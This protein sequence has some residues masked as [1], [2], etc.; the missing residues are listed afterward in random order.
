M[1]HHITRATRHFLLWLL[2]ALAIGSISIRVLLLGVESHKT[3]LESKILE[4]T[5]IPIEIGTLRANMRGF[6]PEIILKD[7]RVLAVDAGDKPAIQLEEVRF[8]INPVQLLFTQHI[9]PS[10]WVSIVGI[11]LSIVRK[12][13]GA[14]SIVGLNQQDSEQPLWLL[15]G[16]HYE[17]LKSDISW[18]DEQRKGELLEFNNV[19]LSIRNNIDDDTH[20]VHFISHL[21]RQYGNMLR[22]SMSFQ[23]DI[24]DTDN[25]N[26]IVYFEG[27]DIHLKEL[28]TGDL[29]LGIKI[30]DGEGGFKI[31][32]Q[33]EKSRL[34]GL[35]GSVQAKN[36]TLH[37]QKKK[38]KPFK[39]SSLTTKFNG[40]IMEDSWRLGVSD[41]VLGTESKLW[42][43]AGFSV[44]ADNELHHL[45]ASVTQLDLQE[46]TELIRFFAPLD[47]EKQ[48]LISKLELKG[49]LKDFSFYVDNE[50]NTYAAN[51]QFENI[52][53]HAFSGFPQLENLTGSIKGTNEKGSINFNTKNGSVFF[54]ELFRNS[55]SINKLTG[56]LRWQQQSDKWQLFSE[57]LL[58]DTKH[59]QTETR[60]AITIPKDDD[61]PVFMDLQSTFANVKDISH[62]PDYYPASIMDKDVLNWLDNAFI[63][64]KIGQGG[65][66]VYGDLDQ[67]PFSDGQGVFE[68]LYNMEDVELQYN[69]DWPNLKNVNADVL[70]LKNGVT[71]ELSNAEVNN[72]TVK[73][74][75]IEIPSFSLSDHLLVKGQIEGKIVDGL[76]FLQK[77]P[78]HEPIDAVLDVITPEGLTHVDLGMRIPL[79]ESALVSVD[80]VAHLKQ[81]A[82]KVKSIDL[83]VSKVSGDLRFTE[84]GLFS[85]LIKANA[86]GF[87]IAIKVDSDKSSTFIDIEGKTNVVQLKKQF[88]FLN[89]DFIGE[90]LKGSTAYQ[91]KLDLP[92]NEDESA[93]LNIKTNLSGI[94]IDMP[95][96]LS[97]SAEQQ[98]PLDL[99][100]LLND[101]ELLPL[102]LNYN[103]QLK[104]ALNIDK[105]QSAMHSAHV[106]YGKGSAVI[107]QQKGINFH[108]DQDSFNLSEWMGIINRGDNREQQS[109]L[110]LLGVSLNTKQLQWNNKSYGS[111]EIAIQRFDKEWQ[112]N[113]TCSVAKG[114]FFIPFELT[115]KDQVKLDMAYLNLSELIQ[116]GDLF[117]EITTE[118][119]PLISVFS[120][121]LWWNNGNLGKLEIE[122][123]KLLDGIRFKRIAVTSADHQI[124]LNADWIKQ[125]N[126]W[127]TELY[128]TLDADDIGAFISQL[129]FDNDFLETSGKVEYFGTWPGSPY[130]FSLANMEAEMDL[131]LKGGRISSIEPGFGRILGLI[132]IEQWVKRL[133]LDFGDLY[134]QGLSINSV[135]GHLK[136]SKGKAITR[137][138]LVNSVPALITIK[139]EA[140][141]LTETLNSQMHVVPKSSGALPIAG[142]IVSSIAG[143]ITQVFT[144]DYK[145]G[146]FFGSK[147]KVTGHWDNIEVTPLHKQDGILKKTWTGLTD[148]SWMKF[149]TEEE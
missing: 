39:V 129:G 14:L 54:P 104:V 85:E 21:P 23:G 63:S 60:V 108:I 122:T 128:G 44:A 97:K 71:I 141:L 102:I 78:L 67:F 51:G 27:S 42:P 112:G 13:D 90:R 95:G 115:G 24:F 72:L 10:S 8:G 118:D 25:I 140:D 148:F 1:I 22:V 47:K 133:T 143:A 100:F 77:T 96:S 146:Y 136:I 149:A 84:L 61:E 147:Y 33:W 49:E 109:E 82:L 70:F 56:L 138:L 16:R 144:S 34:S 17:I 134:K 9:L 99:S 74:A 124:E 66:L 46:L 132:A 89:N 92:V 111:F 91:V 37:K 127:V 107:P 105:Q 64:G 57:S 28:V 123:D 26:G 76:T 101:K 86:M 98:S 4:V 15:Q 5:G 139:G 81:A 30:T 40:L 12:E 125:G 29:P 45:A 119:L 59:I 7:I 6:S 36:I 69:K 43:A 75:R 94:S 48:A 11:K 142:T 31:W 80:G 103:N 126:D 53:T 65:V 58:L 116:I 52:F 41:F 87:P 106:V 19:D 110:E 145:E 120:D 18:L 83:D 50:K 135:T 20:E 131:D 114:A 137:D 93:E 88:S 38:Q 117:D 68:V 35:S 113:L 121:Q 3:D 73:Q 32:S 79:A 62:A 55:F 130:Q 2:I